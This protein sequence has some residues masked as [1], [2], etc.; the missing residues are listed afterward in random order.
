MSIIID[1][2]VG[3]LHLD[4]GGTSRSVV[5]ITDALAARPNILVRL[6][7]QSRFCDINKLSSNPNVQRYIT[8]WYNPLAGYF[9][10]AG[11]KSLHQA[12]SNARSDLIHCN[13]IWHPV[14]HWSVSMAKK[15]RIPLV[16]QPHGMLEPWALA[17]RSTK[18]RFALAS[19][20]RRDLERAYLLVATAPQEAEGFR[21][22]GLTQPIAIIPNG[23][24]SR[25]LTDVSPAD[26]HVRKNGPRRALFLSRIHPKKGLLVMLDAWAKVAPE[27]WVLDLA[28]P[29]ECGHL[30]EVMARASM[31]GMKDRINYLGNF[32]D[33]AKLEVYRSADM[34]VLPSFSENFGIVV[35]EALAQGLPVITTTGTPWQ[36]LEVYGC[37]WWVEPSVAG[38][39]AALRTAMLMPTDSLRMMGLK[40]QNYVQR[41]NWSN[42]AEM[43][44][45]VYYWI[46][47][48]G[49]RPDYV[50]LD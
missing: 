1:H 33:L 23:V 25:V 12:F 17:W 10:L 34:F 2:V 6:I 19:Y 42:I 21:K 24:E 18:K 5:Q 7:S 40:G 32:D 48:H 22:I 35:A 9:G 29:V 3:S 37:G 39:S 15:Q 41:Y 43:M 14:N 50:Y 26:T 28:G 11:L 4:G 31:I 49:S 45:N 16:I 30:D 36:D 46:L 44:E 13:G 8:E 38:L 47:G 27:D 20:Q